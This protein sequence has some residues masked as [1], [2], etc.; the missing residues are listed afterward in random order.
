MR[1]N[2]CQNLRTEPPAASLSF[3]SMLASSAPA[4]VLDDLDTP[5]RHL[6][7]CHN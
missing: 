1:G 3:E 4:L 7:I 5:Y 2:L 6:E